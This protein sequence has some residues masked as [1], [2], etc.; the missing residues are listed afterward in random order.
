MQS[1]GEQTSEPSVSY[2]QL[3]RF[4]WNLVARRCLV[5][6]DTSS[7]SRDSLSAYLAHVR[8]RR[9]VGRR[10]ESGYR[11]CCRAKCSL[12]LVMSV[13]STGVLLPTEACMTWI[14]LI[15]E[16]IA[17]PSVALDTAV[18]MDSALILIHTIR[19]VKI[20][21]WEMMFMSISRCLW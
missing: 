5:A 13:Q 16:R 15:S 7:R 2:I 12:H 4:A 17:T 8:A 19:V 20:V 14:S 9:F 6:L 3:L 1:S 10:W 11:C 21:S 18:P